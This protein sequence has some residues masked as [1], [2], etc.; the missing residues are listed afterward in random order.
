MTTIAVTG[1]GLSGRVRMTWIQD[2]LAHVPEH[3]EVD[4]PSGTWT[5]LASSDHGL[6]F[7]AV[8][9]NAA[10]QRIAADSDIADLTVRAGR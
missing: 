4:E 1:M 5:G 6:T 7:G 8:V 9:D 10:L 2:E 3:C